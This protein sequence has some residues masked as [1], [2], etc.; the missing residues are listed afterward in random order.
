MKFLLQMLE[1]RENRANVEQSHPPAWR[2]PPPMFRAYT[3]ETKGSP[4]QHGGRYQRDEV[5]MGQT[6]ASVRWLPPRLEPSR[7]GTTGGAPRTHPLE[8]VSRWA[9]GVVATYCRNSAVK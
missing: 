1:S 6:A 8:V 7:R 4:L 2:A 5:A 3:G 9:L